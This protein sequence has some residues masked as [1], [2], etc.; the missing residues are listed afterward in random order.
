M[1]FIFPIKSVLTPKKCFSQTF[2]RVI[3]TVELINLMSGLPDKHRRRSAW[4][5]YDSFA[6]TS[7]WFAF[8]IFLK[9]LKLF[10]SKVYYA[11]YFELDIA[12]S[13]LF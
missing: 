11:G 8:V 2:M 13:F 10:E 1:V 6:R 7:K 4:L 9:N 3:L 5:R 12:I